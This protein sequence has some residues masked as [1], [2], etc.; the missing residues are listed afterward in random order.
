MNFS[1]CRYFLCFL[2]SWLALP[3]QES[4]QPESLAA[5]TLENGAEAAETSV[6]VLAISLAPLTK[7]ELEAEVSAW[8]RKLQEKVREIA[9]LEIRVLQGKGAAEALEEH[10]PQLISLRGQKDGLVRRYRTVLDAYEL[11]GGDPE[12]GRKYINAVR[13]IKSG[14]SSISARSQGLK[15][16]F[17]SEDGGILTG[18]LALRFLVIILV[19]WFLSAIVS[20][21]IHRALE[22]R[23][24]VSSLLRTFINK[25]SRRLILFVGVVV[26]LATVGVNVAAALTLIGGGAFILAFAL[27][28]TL[29]NLA[30]G[31]MV[32]FYRPFDVGDAVEIGGVTGKVDSVSLV[33]TTIL[34]FDNRKILIPNKKVWGEVITNISGMTTRRADMLFSIGYE[35][36]LDEAQAIIERVIREHPLILS[37]P[38]PNIGLHEL[39]DSTVNIRC[40]PWVKS[41]DLLTVRTQVTKQIKEEFKAAGISIPFPQ[42]ELHLHG[43]LP[44]EIPSQ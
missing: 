30:N 39:A 27:Q 9:D 17:T 6:E 21:L 7:E 28:D 14:P 3:A 16:W 35:D 11:K 20:K 26:A 44:V 33:S 15:A 8:Q 34:S 23:P 4:A 22:K 12:S 29:G 24:H 10:A 43:S 41:A 5:T 42:R 19:F 25:T 40:W 13:N 1:I 37:D 32:I 36:D 2:L 31:I 18:K 38:A